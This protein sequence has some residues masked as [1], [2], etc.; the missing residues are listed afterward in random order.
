MTKIASAL[1]SVGFLAQTAQATFLPP[2]DLDKQDHVWFTSNISEEDF[3]QIIDELIDIYKPI[4]K[5]HGGNL[6]AN[7][8][9][10]NATVNASAN[11][12]FSSWSVNMYG[13]LARRP[14]VTPDGFA[15]VVCHE[16][17]HHLGGF[18]FVSSWAANEGQADYFATQS[19]ARQIWGNQLEKNASFREAVSTRAKESCDAV[20]ENADEQNLCYR[21]AAAGESLAKLLAALGDAPVPSLETPDTSVVTE[22]NNAHPAAQCR[23]D[24]YLAGAICTAN[25]DSHKIPGRKARGGQGSENAELDASQYSCTAAGQFTVGL[26]PT[27]WFK[28]RL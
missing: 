7:K 3:N 10:T 24:T 11:Q 25:F 8:Q 2:N 16:L 14:E 17:G 15:M 26:R 28:P 22:T 20:W 23:L 19:C 1:L 4:A 27:C 5:E 18:P 12:F 9:W 6:R 13:G 21:T